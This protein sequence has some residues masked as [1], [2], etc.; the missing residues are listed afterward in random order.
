MDA[1]VS[2]WILAAG[3]VVSLVACFECQ[4]SFAAAWPIRAVKPHAVA[5]AKPFWSAFFKF[6]LLASRIMIWCFGL[7]S[8]KEFKHGRV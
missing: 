7:S 2:V 1:G 8:W 5:R 6:S 3:G 4:T